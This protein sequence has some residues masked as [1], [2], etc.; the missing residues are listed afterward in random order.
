MT[1]DL[2]QLFSDYSEVYTRGEY[3]TFPNKIIAIQFR[4]KFY[5]FEQANQVIEKESPSFI[6][7]VTGEESQPADIVFSHEFDR[8]LK[9]DGFSLEVTDKAITVKT[10][11]MRGFRY[12]KE[13]FFKLWQ[14]SETGIN[15]PLISI[16][17]T[18]S[19]QLRGVIEG[20]YGIP[21]TH[22]DR[23]DCLHFLG[24]H[25]LNTYMYAPKDDE[26]QR[27]LWRKP[28]PEQEL[29]KFK[30]LLVVAEEE[31]VDFWYMISPG[32]DIAYTQPEEMKV[33]TDKLDQLINLGIRHFGLL[34]DDIDYILKGEA[35]KR[36]SSSASAHAFIISQVDQYLSQVLH[37]YQLVACP[38]E[39]DN[40]H[41][42]L[43]LEQLNE[44]LPSHIPLFWTGPST[45]ASHIR[46]KDIELMASIY[47]RPM[48]IW[49]NVPVNDYQ[50][51]YEL[52]FMSPYENRSPYL[53]QASFNVQ[54]IVSNPMA[55]WEISKLTVDNMSRYLWDTQAYKVVHAW[56]ET[57][58]HYTGSTELAEALK[59][60][61]WH[62]QNK[63][64]QEPI[65]FDIK[66]GI[67]LKDTEKLTAYLEQLLKAS[68][69]LKEIDQPAFQEKIAPW[70]AR[71]EKDWQFWQTI[72]T[73]DCQK[74][75]KEKEQLLT[76]PHRIGTNIPMN[77]LEK[78]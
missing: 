75:A 8:N 58:E 2:S 53:N 23:L 19:F 74:I 26:Y 47:Q 1:T 68:R 3:L 34:L 57:L 20:F 33:L 6:K 37:D 46:T 49:D 9:P 39:Y 31:Q 63:Y 48:I 56:Q 60:F 32:N 14:V 12:A 55:Q 59:I 21:W 13:A 52:L 62:N 7:W 15:C 65:P 17:H 64:T 42:S 30:E 71:C 4:G 40:S 61:A 70:L 51:D 77:Y 67:R 41:D 36:F 72:L 76:Y 5:R 25:R 35:K 44:E 27:K 24:E 11:N 10:K 78:H 66:E 43:Y 45:L 29:D 54:G 22:E 16:Y 38:T 69:Q 18:P 50:K 28:Y 73:E